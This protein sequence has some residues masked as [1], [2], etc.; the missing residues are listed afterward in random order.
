MKNRKHILIIDD[1]EE[2]RDLLEDFFKKHNFITEIFSNGI[3]ALKNLETNRPDLVITDLLLPGEP[4]LEHFH[5]EGRKR[6]GAAP[7]VEM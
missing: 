2:I 1:V 6:T 4:A 7:A 3:L 5:R